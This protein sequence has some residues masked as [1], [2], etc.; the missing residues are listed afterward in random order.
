VIF[1]FQKHSSDIEKNLAYR[2]ESLE[3]SLVLRTKAMREKQ[4]Q[5]EMR[6][7]KYALVRV[8]FPDG[9]FLQVSWVG[10]ALF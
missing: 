4:E 8:R 7:Y 5:K 2:Q 6:R 10:Y 9:I 1:F 3:S